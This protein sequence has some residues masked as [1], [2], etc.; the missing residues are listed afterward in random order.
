M[1]HV[2]PIP[3]RPRPTRRAAAG[4]LGG[5]LGWVV[6]LLAPPGLG[7]LPTGVYDQLIATTAARYGF[8]PALVKAVITCESQ[9]NPLAQSPRGAQGLMQ[10]MP[11]TQ[12]LLGVRDAFDPQDNVEEAWP[13]WR[14]CSTPSRTA[15][16]WCW[17]PIMRDRKPSSRQATACHPSPKPSATW[18]ASCGPGHVPTVQ[19]IAALP[20]PARPPRP[21]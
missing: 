5:L 7:A 20:S 9:F 17:R 21:A 2:A 4:V 16:P 10:L 19:A 15:S 1:V 12:T 13:T 8:D 18:P 14:C 11:A 6:W 3:Q